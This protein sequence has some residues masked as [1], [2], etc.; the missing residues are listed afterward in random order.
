MPNQSLTQA[1]QHGQLSSSS[2]YST[3]PSPAAS[4]SQNDDDSYSDYMASE[5]DNKSVADGGSE[6]GGRSP[7]P[8]PSVYSYSS[9]VDAQLIL[10]DAFGRVINNVSDFYMMPGECA[11]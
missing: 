10:R 3:S 11:A 6:A 8:A 4:N 2:E 7:S 1:E 9:S 5:L